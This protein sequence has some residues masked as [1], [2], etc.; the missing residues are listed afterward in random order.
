MTLNVAIIARAR[1]FTAL[2]DLI[3][4]R[5]AFQSGLQSWE[6][7]YVILRAASDPDLTFGGGAELNLARVPATL[8]SRSGTGLAALEAAWRAA[9]N[10]FDGVA[11]GLKVT[12]WIT[13]TSD[14]AEFITDSQSRL[15]TRTLMTMYSYL[16]T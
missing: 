12:A 13:G 8:Y 15:A 14:G 11:G 16:R 9:F 10:R 6:P 4:G 2:N 1:S 5:I 7:P 3:S